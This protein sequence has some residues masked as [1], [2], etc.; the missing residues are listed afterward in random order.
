[1]IAVH[2]RTNKLQKI[3]ENAKV[4]SRTYGDEMAERIHLRIDQITSAN[5]VEELV[6]HRI[7]RCHLL[8]GDRKGQ[9]AMDLIQPYR[10]IFVKIEESSVEVRIENIED[11]H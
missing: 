10:L 11:Y 7:G 3:C 8:I 2:Y 5:N 9:Y 6:Q 1:M 4:A